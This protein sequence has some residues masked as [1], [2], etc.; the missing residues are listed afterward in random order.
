MQRCPP[1]GARLCEH[2]RTV[3]KV[4]SRHARPRRAWRPAAANAA[5]RRSSNEAP[6][7]D[8][9]RSRTR[10]ACRCAVILAPHCLP[11]PPAEVGS[12]QQK[13]ARHAH[14][15]SGWPTTR[16]SSAA[17]VGRD[18]GQLR[19]LRYV[20]L[21]GSGALRP[22]TDNRTEYRSQ[23]VQYRGLAPGLR[24]FAVERSRSMMRPRNSP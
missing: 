12:T 19:H 10:S 4:E 20:I 6:A 24:G 5:D 11:H 17:D 14:T 23:I 18:V 1:L 8:R 21:S 2:Q 13:G 7:I 22:G 16:A 3:G 9:H 15:L